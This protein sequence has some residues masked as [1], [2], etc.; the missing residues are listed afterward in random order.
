MKKLILALLAV[1]SIGTANAQRNSV[2]MY[3]NAYVATDNVDY[4]PYNVRTT[5]LGYQPRRWLPGN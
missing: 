3:G 4:G 2:L 1:V 5:T